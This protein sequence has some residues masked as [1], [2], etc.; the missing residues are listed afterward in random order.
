MVPCPLVLQVTVDQIGH[1]QAKDQDPLN[2][3]LL[4]LFQDLVKACTQY[5]KYPGPY[6]NAEANKT[7]YL[8]SKI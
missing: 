7:D 2:L 5:A 1:P 4:K 8:T 6:H 3:L